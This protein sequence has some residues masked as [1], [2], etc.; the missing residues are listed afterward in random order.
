MH[1]QPEGRICGAEWLMTDTIWLIDA[2]DNNNNNNW[3][4]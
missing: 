3:L 2:R 1:G 4:V